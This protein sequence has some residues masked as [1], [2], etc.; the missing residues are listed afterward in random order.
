MKTTT[1]VT[2]D[3]PRELIDDEEAFK[4]YWQQRATAGAAWQHVDPAG[5]RDR[6]MLSCNDAM[7]VA[8]KGIVPYLEE[9]SPGMSREGA[10]I[11]VTCAQ[12][13]KVVFSSWAGLA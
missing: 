4:K 1:M 5:D 12:S 10:A 3:V 13:G 9:E 11:T 8:L 2:F 6:A 7:R